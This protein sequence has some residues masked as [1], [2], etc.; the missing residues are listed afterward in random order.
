VLLIS[1]FLF[2]AYLE[3]LRYQNSYRMSQ[4]NHE[5]SVGVTDLSTSSFILCN[6]VSCFSCCKSKY[7]ERNSA[8]QNNTKNGTWNYIFCCCWCKRK[9]KRVGPFHDLTLFLFCFVSLFRGV[10]ETSVVAVMDQEWGKSTGGPEHIW[11]DVTV[12]PL[13][14]CIEQGNN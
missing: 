13:L 12:T 1:V 9:E 3:T 10:F 11:N 4:Y 2:V 5:S 7:L 6:N 8:K 14:T